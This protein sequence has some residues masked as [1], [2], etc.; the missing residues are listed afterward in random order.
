MYSAAELKKLRKVVA[1]LAE[2]SNVE[3]F[4]VTKKNA[5]A[6]HAELR[7]GGLARKLTQGRL[8]TDFMYNYFSCKNGSYLT[9]S[10]LLND[11]KPSDREYSGSNEK[12]NFWWNGL[13]IMGIRE[14]KG[15]RNICGFVVTHNAY[16]SM[17]PGADENDYKYD[18]VMKVGSTKI[19]Q[20]MGDSESRFGS[21]IWGDIPILCGSGY[22]DLLI[23]LALIESGF[24]KL[25]VSVAEGEDNDA[26]QALLRRWKFGKLKMTHPKS[27]KPWR[28]EDGEELNVQQRTEKI[29]AS[30]ILRLTKTGP[31]SPR[32]P[33]KASADK[34]KSAAAAAKQKKQAAADKAAK[35]KAEAAKKKK[36][37]AAK[38]KAAQAEAKKKAAA[39]KAAKKKEEAAKKSAA[40]KAADAEKRAKQAEAAKAKLE[41]IKEKTKASIEKVKAS[42]KASVEKKDAQIA[43]FK[44][45][46]KEKDQTIAGLKKT[47]KE[48]RLKFKRMRTEIMQGVSNFFKTV[49]LTTPAK[50]TSVQSRTP[51]ASEKKEAAS[52]TPASARKGRKRKSAPTAS[53]SSS[54]K[55]SRTT[56]AARTAPASRK[57][58]RSRRRK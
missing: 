29:Q 25:L 7:K 21:D 56:R 26:M 43:K 8:R 33:S 39:K 22:G 45:T 40:K 41:A 31:M 30:E 15:R 54:A 35:K 52:A 9:G 34:K 6:I 28:D 20:E 58:T 11:S 50:P 57:R 18:P 14:T 53:S 36:E 16:L 42:V 44:E 48:L 10:L 24:P 38:K 3:V 46:V 51:A 37:A 19:N 32:K 1:D 55:K 2:Q 13:K 5:A 4:E 12:A 17:Y 49:D 47:N 27:R 23:S